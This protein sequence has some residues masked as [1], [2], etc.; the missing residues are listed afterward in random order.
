MQIAQTNETNVLDIS[1]ELSSSAGRFTNKRI[2]HEM[3]TQLFEV[4]VN[5]FK[6]NNSQNFDLLLL[7]VEVFK[8][9]MFVFTVK[10]FDLTKLV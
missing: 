5:L 7:Y 4:A 10:C 8:T 3:F 2:F 9:T 6:R 1:K